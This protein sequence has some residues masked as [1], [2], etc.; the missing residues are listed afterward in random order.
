MSSR[1]RKRR[2]TARSTTRFE[3]GR[4]AAA[5]I[6]AL[7]H[8]LVVAHGLAALRAGFADFGARRR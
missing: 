8:L 7:L 6:G 2:R 4:A 3:I 5:D 1:R